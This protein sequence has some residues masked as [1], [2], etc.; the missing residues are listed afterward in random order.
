MATNIISNGDNRDETN[1]GLSIQNGNGELG[2][3]DKD[4]D[5]QML[6]NL[7]GQTVMVAREI[8]QNTNNQ[9]SEMKR[10]NQDQFDSIN[11]RLFQIENNEEVTTEQEEDI[12]KSAKRRVFVIIGSDEYDVQRYFAPFIQRLYAD[13]RKCVGL[14]SKIS[15]T[16]KGD[17]ERIITFIESWSPMCGISNFKKRVDDRAAIRK[18]AREDGY[19]C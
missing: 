17:Y 8:G 9:I 5:M 18:K 13:A 10:Y 14:G 3:F 16:K 7:I 15:R 2:N 19:I 6:K 12:K 1:N 4:Y 11:Q